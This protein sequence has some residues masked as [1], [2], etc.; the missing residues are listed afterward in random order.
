MSDPHVDERDERSAARLLEKLHGFTA[1][2]EPEE[3][4]LFA[5][6]LAPGID[7]AWA[8]DAEVAGFGVQWTASRLPEHLVASIRARELRIEGW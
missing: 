6:L 8:D 1:S 5:A 3:R 4:R 7:A 2:L